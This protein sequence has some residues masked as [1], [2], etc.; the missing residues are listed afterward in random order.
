MLDIADKLAYVSRDTSVILGGAYE[1]QGRTIKP[2]YSEGYHLI[3]ELILKNPR[4]CH[5][6]EHAVRKDE[7]IAFT[8]GE[9][10][11]DFLTL[12]ALLFKHLYYNPTSRF[13]E[14]MFGKGITS[15]F[16]RTGILTRKDLLRMGDEELEW[17]MEKHTGVKYPFHFIGKLTDA[18]Y[19]TFK[20]ENQMLSF[21][22]KKK[23]DKSILV[24]VDDFNPHTST[25]VRKF[26][27]QKR[28]GI[29]RFDEAYP[30][31]AEK[32]ADIMTFPRQNGVYT[33]SMDDLGVPIERR[34]DFKKM[35]E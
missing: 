34:A 13:F 12:R 21:V 18:Q 4:L 19:D 15:Y 9:Q 23:K 26:F 29:L 5:I 20:T 14:Y 27:V 31:V 35:I 28:S 22:S 8:N 33:L 16:Y 7:Q 3:G 24:L 1:Y 11:G 25:S 2:Y 6:W 10:L 17:V 32:I 30:R